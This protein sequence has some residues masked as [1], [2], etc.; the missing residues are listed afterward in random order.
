MDLAA[1][2]FG[3]E[4]RV[5]SSAAQREIFSASCC[6]PDASLAYNQ[7]ISLFF[8]DR[9]DPDALYSALLNL[10]HRHEALR[11]HFSTDGMSF[12]IRERIAF[13]LPLIELA[14]ETALER[15]ASYDRAVQ[16][17]LGHVFNLTEGPL[18]RAL[19]FSR[20]PQGWVLLF[21]CHH[22]VVDGWSLNIILRELPA[23]YSDLVS[24]RSVASLPSPDSFAA[25]LAYAVAQERKLGPAAYRYWRQ[26]FAD[27]VPVLD[28]PLDRIRPNTRTYQSRRED[29]KVERSVYEN[30]KRAGAKGGTTQFGTLMAVYALYLARISGQQDFVIGVP[31]FGQVTAGKGNLLG[32]DARLIPVRCVIEEQDN[33]TDFA[34]RLRRRFLE[35]YDHQWVSI[36]GLI[37]ELGVDVDRAR[38]PLVSAIFG[39]DP[40]METPFRFGDLTAR[41]HYNE[42]LGET[43][44]IQLNAVVEDGELI[45]EWSYNAALFDREQMHARLMQFEHLM[46]AIAEQ[47]DCKVLSLPLLPGPQVREMEMLLNQTAF[48]FERELCVDQLVERSVDA[49]PQA[50]AVE[51]GDQR[52]SYRQLWDRSG[53]VANA[54]AS[55]GAGARSLVGVML[56]RSADLVAVLLG[57]WRAGA[58]FVPLD[59]AYPADRL[60]YMVEHSG[61]RVLL[62]ERALERPEDAQRLK[63]IYAS[64]IAPETPSTFPWRA[65]RNSEDRAYVIYTSGSTGKPKGVQVPHRSLNNFLTSM[66]TREP[67][68]APAGRLLAVTTLSFD[69]A[70]LEL[71]LPLVSGGTT[72]IA[73]RATAFDGAALIRLLSS[74]RITV[75]QATPAT[76]RLLLYSG[77][78]GDR[79][80][81]ALCG[82]EALPRDLADAL[83]ERVGILW[84]VYGPTETTVWSTIDRVGPGA[85]AVGKPIGNT[86]TYILNGNNEWVPRGSVG[87]LWIGGDGVTAGYLGREDLTRERFL[88]N[89]FTGHGLMYRTGDLVRLRLDGRLEYIGR[90]D[91][92]VKVRGYRIELGEVQHTLARLPKIRQCIVVVKE[93]EPGDSHLVAYY[94]LHSGRQ[95][96]AT[97]LKDELRQSLPDYMIPGWFV[98]LESL[99]LTDN[100][101]INVKALPD[102]FASA[103]DNSAESDKGLHLVED[104]LRGTP[105]ITECALLASSPNEPDRR[106][107]AFLVRHGPHQPTVIAVR[108][109]LVGKVPEALIPDTVISLAEL[110]LSKSRQVDRSRLGRL[111]PSQGIEPTTDTERLLMSTWRTLLN[112]K[113]VHRDDRFFDLGGDSLLAVQLVQRIL[114]ITG[115]GLEPRDIATESLWK[116]AQN[117][118]PTRAVGEG[119]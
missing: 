115:F 7:S 15:K 16:D 79:D 103:P 65:G 28:L 33:F 30:L 74:A 27:G 96:D 31:A 50:I 62:T 92:Q 73:D 1:K 54:L 47:P 88:P 75:L 69:I 34:A 118:L 66:R 18:F 55:A 19:L 56:E 98:E 40:G 78:A 8:S 86:Q 4:I 84:N 10:L 109:M 3:A 77:W 93:R 70:E 95:T 113:A 29:Y 52:L 99:P 97:E 11:G 80:L 49:H 91:F 39:F 24:D 119:Q 64:E 17:E 67:G 42:R 111:I 51:F 46:R 23:L 2:H 45:L 41:H 21:N 68:F 114:E 14:G 117:I 25:H 63:C 35:A 101:K 61:M 44:E 107:V 48:P 100:G 104:I 59:P 38:A 85:I 106:P 87:E 9:P 22:A 83:L 20:A 43:F 105:T 60:D 108:K 57:V 26:T 112:I 90:N 82:G 58:A 110:P 71:W 116:L 53:Q 94:T 36:P 6:S 89:V 5:A 37:R 13:E 102:P 81:T 76:W 32:H 72:V 12:I